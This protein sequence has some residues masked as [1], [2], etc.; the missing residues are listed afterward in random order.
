M[1]RTFKTFEEFLF[2]K[3]GSS[4]LQKVYAVV[5]TKIGH[6]WAQFEGSDAFIVIN[7]KNIDSIKAEDINPDYPILNYS[8]KLL[9]KLQKKVVKN[10]V[11]NSTEEIQDSMSKERFHKKVEGNSNVPSTAYNKDEALKIGFPLIAKP[12]EGH[13]GQGIKIFKSEKEFSEEDLSKYDVFSEFVDKKSEH[14][15]INFNGVPFVWMERT[16]LNA[17]AKS[18]DGSS[19]EK[20]EFKYTKR[21]ISGIP[22][23]LKK[24]NSSF[25]KIFDSIKLICFDIME[26]QE[27][28]AYV[29]ESNTMTGMPFDIALE[30]YKEIFK[31]HFGKEISPESSKEIEN[32]S[33]KLIQRTFDREDNK[34]EI[35]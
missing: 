13:S 15:I 24:V 10:K 20:M 29:I 30:L 35:K 33:D 27:G 19:E 12:K 6:Q 3:A 1:N 34:W 18:G 23:N 16:P 32:L 4:D 22:E 2:E 26:D 31:D 17:K 21:K 11:Y 25:C 8:I 9:E 28:K 5:N 14:R 7:Q